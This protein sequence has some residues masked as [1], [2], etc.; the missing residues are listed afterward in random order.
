MMLTNADIT[1]FNR[2]YDNDS[3]EYK[4]A[5]TFLRGVNWQDSQA[6]NISQSVGVKSMNH[7]RVFIPLKVDSEEKTYL[8]P[9]TFKRSDK[10]TNYTLD[11]A[12]IVV[13]GIVDFD[14]NDAHSGGFKALLRDFDDVMKITKVVDNRYGSKLV[15]HFEL[16]V[17]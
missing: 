9:K 14:M 12:D 11:N 1:L 7:T 2:Y 10:V 4:Y 17:E 15:Q 6:I 13:K 16:E 5:R 8:K 3:G